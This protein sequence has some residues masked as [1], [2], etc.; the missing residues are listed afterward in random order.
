MTAQ[1]LR[2]VVFVQPRSPGPNA[3]LSMSRYTARMAGLL[4]PGVEVDTVRA[5]HVNM[6]RPFRWMWGRYRGLAPLPRR[7]PGGFDL[8]HF[9][10]AYVSP[11][12]DRFDT[13]RVTTIHD[14]M[15]FEFRRQ[16]PPKES[17]AYA[18]FRRSLGSL[19]RV[20][21]TIAPSETTRRAVLEATSLAPGRVVTVA[22]PLPKEI[23]PAPGELRTPGTILSVGTTAPYKNLPV[24]LYALAQPDLRGARLVRIGSPLD[25]KLSALARRLGV[26]GRIEE[27]GFVDDEHLL[28]ALRT[29]SVMAQPSFSE[30]FGMPV[31]EAMATGLPVVVSN[32]GALP[33]VAGA[34]GKVIPL[35]D[36]APGRRP[37][38]DDARDFARA[39]AE[40]LETP[41]LA[42]SMS[43]AGIRE[44]ERFR[45][46]PLG[47]QLLAAYATAIEFAKARTGA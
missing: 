33:E 37:N 20:D 19:D 5:T 21:V 34:A 13:A 6:R 38:I 45:E 14:M 29:C 2:R 7:W 15:P 43:A 25:R 17:W 16:W 39:L 11:H 23:E 31:A 22:I 12:A 44:S 47:E 41:T 10:D 35:R 4:P 28:R 9:T 26:D 8:V 24:L 30:G 42:A 27:L 36:L 32:G 40:V 1:G 3:W 18:L 46:G